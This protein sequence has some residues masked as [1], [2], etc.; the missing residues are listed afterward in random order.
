MFQTCVIFGSLN[1]VGAAAAEVP[2]DAKAA[3]TRPPAATTPARR[4]ARRGALTTRPKFD[5]ITDNSFRRRG[6][7]IDEVHHICGR[8][9]NRVAGRGF[10][11]CLELV[12]ARTMRT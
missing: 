5:V 7:K 8:G 1:A 4:R 11:G 6:D 12:G 9:R 10:P 2:D 3:T